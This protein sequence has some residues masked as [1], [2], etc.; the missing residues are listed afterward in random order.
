MTSQTV[1]MIQEEDEA[2]ALLREAI[3]A[4]AG[5]RVLTVDHREGLDQ[6]LRQAPAVILLDLTL[7]RGSGLAMLER[8]YRETHPVPVVVFTTDST[9]QD[10][11]AAVR[12][13]ATRFL[14]D[15]GHV[16]QVLAAI[17]EA[18]DQEMFRKEK[19]D[20]AQASAHLNRQ[21]QQQVR[22]WTTLND[23]A[24]VISSTLE[25]PEIFRRVMENVTRILKVEACSLL[26][27]DQETGEL[28]FAVTL[29]GD[30]ARYS[31]FRLKP[32]QGIAGW[33]AQQ[34]ESLLIPDVHEDA[35][36]F[37]DV[38]QATGFR[39]HSILCVPVKARDEVIGV[40]EAINKV[41]H[42]EAPVFSREDLDMLTTLASW[43]AVAVEN[44]GLNRA[45]KKMAA[46][47]ALRQ[48]VTAVAHH[49]NN[50][51]MALSLDLDALED[52]GPI[53]RKAVH[54][55]T[56]SARRSIEE[57]TAVIKAL[58]RLEDIR[59]VPYVGAVE[60]IDIEEGLKEEMR[61][62]EDRYG[63]RP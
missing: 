31:S 27:V 16:D 39:S 21:L 51:L 1:L 38:D 49:I 62:I 59:V 33:V 26:L 12:L 50:R 54:G 9:K 48:T 14:E 22:N 7:K 5:Y 30:A 20:L 41:D 24:Q 4:R 60:M 63:E 2:H 43:V 15:R 23:I 3:N 10:I 58:D 32:G 28:A 25:E 45:A 55:V 6:A 53:D 61:L 47:T 57:V 18:L 56:R 37:P 40:I 8:I 34:G 44:A 42:P 52:E 17:Q 36:F 19:A 11:L 13:G 29:E 46:E 35:R